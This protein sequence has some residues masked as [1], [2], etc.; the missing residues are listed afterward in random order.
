M[1]QK[2]QYFAELA[3]VLL[4]FNRH[5]KGGVEKGTVGWKNGCKTNKKKES[6]TQLKKKKN[7]KT[8]PV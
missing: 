2:F 6:F 3:V 8:T 1:F 7:Q 5:V 4:M